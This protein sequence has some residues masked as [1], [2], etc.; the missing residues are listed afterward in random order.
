MP[1]SGRP[2][3]PRPPPPNPQ[4]RASRRLPLVAF[5]TGATLAS[6]AAWILWPGQPP[7]PT[8]PAPAAATATTTTTAAAASGA[9]AARSEGPSFLGKA[10]PWG[11]LEYTPIVI[12]PPRDLVRVDGEIAPT[13]WSFPQH[14]RE[15]AERV[16][17]D[18]G[19]QPPALAALARAGWRVTAGTAMVIP[20]R[21]IIVDLP[22]AVRAALY[23]VLARYPENAHNAALAFTSAEFERRLAASNL[24][25]ATVALLRKLLYQRG[26]IVFFADDRT[27]LTM[28]DDQEERVRVALFLA[29]QATFAVRLRVDTN[30]DVRRLLQYWGKPGRSKDIEPILTSLAAVPGGYA[31][32]L[33]HL[34]PPIPR[35][36]IY[37]Y[38]RPTQPGD[39]AKNCHWTSL[40]FYAEVSDDRFIHVKEA[41]AEVNARFRLVTEPTFGDL[42]VLVDRDTGTVVHSA[43]YLADDL[44]FTKNGFGV[45]EPWMYMQLAAMAE[46]YALQLGKPDGIKILL[47]RRRQT[48]S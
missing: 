48:P 19:F 22:P 23:A 43:T 25:P 12:A 42:V 10:G 27:L 45:S 21:E 7:A 17:A 1:S 24:A 33:A 11:V 46:Q 18:A 31:L 2:P 13:R 16:L 34:L 20:P 40:N 8:G 4:P 26:D 36:R 30:T 9:P 32:D 29:R 6:G 38:P 37:T 14:T 15:Q 41:R 47:Y 3:N 5:A 28:L 44:V 39:D 35:R